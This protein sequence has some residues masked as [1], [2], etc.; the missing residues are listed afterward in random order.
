MLHGGGALIARDST[1]N[2]LLHARDA[3]TP[4]TNR[5]VAELKGVIWVLE[6]VRDLRMSSVVIA[7][8]HSDT[9][10]A[11][12]APHSW[13]RYR[14]LL[15]HIGSLGGSFISVSF[16]V[17]K[18]GANFISREIARSVFRDGRFQSY[19]S[20]GRTGMA[21]QLS[22]TRKRLDKTFESFL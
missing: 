17:E 10:E 22:L 13:P 4:S 11:I 21:S 15:E 2:V 3:F 7:S 5:L 6:S 1:G 20:I 19:I 18:I 14:S 8:D 16:E 12:L 9:V